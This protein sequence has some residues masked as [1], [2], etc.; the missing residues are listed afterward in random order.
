MFEAA[1][2]LPYVSTVTCDT[3][4][5]DPYVPAVAPLTGNTLVESVPD[6]TFVALIFEIADPFEAIRR[7]V[8]VMAVANRLVVVTLFETTR[9]ARGCVKP[10]EVMFERRPP[11]P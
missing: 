2:T 5:D 4:A 3:F 1:V 6:A 11:S 9:L 10:E 7:P 8:T